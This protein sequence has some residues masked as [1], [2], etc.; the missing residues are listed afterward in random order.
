M[1]FY[2]MYHTDDP[3][4]SDVLFPTKKER[5]AYIRETYDANDDGVQRRT[6]EF[7]GPLTKATL[8]RI[9]QSWPMR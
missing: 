7:K 4:Q 5:E 8:C 2:G 6:L 1:R 3:A 9:Y